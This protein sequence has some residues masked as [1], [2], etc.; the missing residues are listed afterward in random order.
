MILTTLKANLPLL[1]AGHKNVEER[2]MLA[3]EINPLNDLFKVDWQ[4]YSRLAEFLRRVSSRTDTVTRIVKFFMLQR[5]QLTIKEFLRVLQAL[6]ARVSA[7]K[8]FGDRLYELF[9]ECLPSWLLETQLLTLENF[10]QL[11][12][13][14]DLPL[15]RSL[16]TEFDME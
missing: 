8:G 7:S 16:I 1:E 10:G 11:I 5:R 15:I 4:A 14:L 9:Q 13:S 6:T 3:F 12:E 2:L